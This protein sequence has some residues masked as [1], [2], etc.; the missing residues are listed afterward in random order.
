MKFQQVLDR[1]LQYAGPWVLNTNY[2]NQSLFSFLFFFFSVMSFFERWLILQVHSFWLSMS[3]GIVRILWTLSCPVYRHVILLRAHASMIRRLPW[4]W[5]TTHPG[6]Y[7]SGWTWWGLIGKLP[8]EE[9]KRLSGLSYRLALGSKLVVVYVLCF[10][11][12]RQSL[13]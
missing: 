9:W 6:K 8:T 1:W 2:V 7:W 10:R 5:V 11:N 13:D 3:E 4:R 12:Y